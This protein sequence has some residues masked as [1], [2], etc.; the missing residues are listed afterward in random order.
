MKPTSLKEIY[1]SLNKHSDTIFVVPLIR[2]SHKQSDYLY[3]LYK[4]LI[5]SD[6]YTIKS[7]SVFKHI[8]LLTGI[9]RNRNAILH[10]HWLEFQDFKSL[11]GL[12]WKMTCIFLF[13]ML[14]GS[15]VWTLHN[16]FPHDQR[17]L[18]LHSLLH[19]KMASWATILHVH[20]EHAATIMQQRLKVNEDKFRWVPHPNFPAVHID[21]SQA[22]GQLNTLYDISLNEKSPILLMFGNISQYKQLE[23]VSDIII[24]QNQDCRLLIAGP[25]KK[26]N[27]GLYRSLLEKQKE[28]ERIQIIPEFIPEDRIPLFFNSADLCVYNYREILSSGS[29]H[30]AT[31]YN[32]PVIAPNKGCLSHADGSDRVTLFQK[33]SELRELLRHYI[34]NWDHG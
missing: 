22:I 24:E 1:A 33:Q 13:K 4:D 6:E 30:L 23:E 15:I 27:M 34:R 16:E 12:P 31:S 19:K 3:L 25:I 28:C 9:L 18:K 10:Y 29:F 20:C 2:Y 14:G 21:R 11:L 32:R 7:I 17:Y 8:K 5:E 26:G